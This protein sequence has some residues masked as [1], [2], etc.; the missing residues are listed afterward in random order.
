LNG[1]HQLLAYADDSNI[2][3]ENIDTTRKNTETLLDASKKVGLEVNPE[4]IKYML[5]SRSQKV[6]QK[7]SI[8]IA[9]RSFEDVTKFKYLETT[10]TDQ[11]CIHE[12]I[13][14]RLNSVN[15]CYHLVQSLLTSRLLCRNVKVKIYKTKILPVVLYGCETWSLILRK[16]HRLRVFEN[17]VLRRIFGPK[18][19]EITEEW[20]KL[21]NGSFIIC[22][23][24]PILLGRSNQ[25]ERDGRGMWTVRERGETCTGFWWESPKENTIRKTKA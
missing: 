7:Y 5:M 4:K 1:T 9:N 3:G 17:R 6:G 22:T 11:N 19:D 14:S 25:G 24:H 12:E 18:W 10:L 16:E 23:N 13:K 21:H 8:K 15:A 20:R 2:V